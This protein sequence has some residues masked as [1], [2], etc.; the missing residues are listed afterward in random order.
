MKSVQERK[1]CN[2][3]NKARASWYRNEMQCSH[4]AQTVTQWQVTQEGSGEERMAEN[5]KL[6]G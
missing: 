3:K 6:P 4:L 5:A 1:N 2:L